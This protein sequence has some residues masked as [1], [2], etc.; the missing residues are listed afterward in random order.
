MASSPAKLSKANGKAKNTDASSDVEYQDGDTPAKKAKSSVS[1]KPPKKKTKEEIE[2]DEDNKPLVARPPARKRKVKQEESS[3][4][5]K[6]IVKKAAAKPKG[7]KVK[8][9][10]SELDTPKPTR[11]RASKKAP[12]GETETKPKPKKKEKKEEEEEEVFRWWEAN[13]G[14]DGS[15][16]WTTLEHNGV[17]F[18]PPYEPLPADVKMKYN[19][20]SISSPGFLCI[21][22]CT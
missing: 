11:K 4:D 5:D 10:A 9:E 20:V 2:S 8:E 18:P 14:G 21:Y 3:D 1:R 6:P 15:V 19:G 7:K 16:K 22:V 12:A 13:P 17:I